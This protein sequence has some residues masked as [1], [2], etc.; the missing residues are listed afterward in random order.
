[1]DMYW[2][3]LKKM[4]YYLYTIDNTYSSDNVTKF[5]SALWFLNLCVHVNVIILLRSDRWQAEILVRFR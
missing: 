5:S 3:T 2:E 1:M 4:T